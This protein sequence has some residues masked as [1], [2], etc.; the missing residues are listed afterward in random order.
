MIEPAEQDQSDVRPQRQRGGDVER[1]AHNRQG[2]VGQG[3]HQM[4]RRGAAINEQC[5][6]GLDQRGG[7]SAERSLGR[8]ML[9]LLGRHHVRG[10][11]SARHDIAAEIAETLRRFLD[12]AADRHFGDAQQAGGVFQMQRR[13]VRERVGERGDPF[14]VPGGSHAAMNVLPCASA[15][16]A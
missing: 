4:R 1:V 7:D 6:V 15:E 12:V 13:G 16:S 3:A 11:A 8:L 10:V 14:G 9:A 5:V 2:H